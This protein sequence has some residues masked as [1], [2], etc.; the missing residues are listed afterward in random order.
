MTEKKA[1]IW[2]GSREE[3]NRGLFLVPHAF[4]VKNWHTSMSFHVHAIPDQA[5]MHPVSMFSPTVLALKRPDPPTHTHTHR[6]D[7]E[8]WVRESAIQKIGCTLLRR[9]CLV[10]H[11]LLLCVGS[12]AGRETCSRAWRKT[13][14][15]SPGLHLR[16][17]PSTGEEEQEEQTECR[18]TGRK[19]KGKSKGLVGEKCQEGHAGIKEWAGISFTFRG[20]FKEGKI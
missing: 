10:L 3:V 6:V 8:K 17:G 1:S 11:P 4:S 20:S 14:H 2:V 18:V 9:Q 5:G 16:P 7:M 12:C 13:R 15:S 19:E